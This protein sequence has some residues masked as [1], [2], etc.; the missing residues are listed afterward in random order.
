MI[1]VYAEKV[2]RSENTMNLISSDKLISFNNFF[3]DHV[4]MFKIVGGEIF[5]E[6][7]EEDDDPLQMGGDFTLSRSGSIHIKI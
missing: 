6:S 2:V 7:K 3:V 1:H 5:P 4:M